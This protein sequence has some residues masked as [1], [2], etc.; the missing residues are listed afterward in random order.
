MAANVW[1]AVASGEAMVVDSGTGVDAASIVD[2]VRRAAA[3]AVVRRVHLTHWHC[4]HCGGAA[5]LRHAFGCPV[6]MHAEEARAVTDGDASLTLGAFL[7]LAQ[8]ACPVEPVKEG[9]TLELGGLRFEVLKLPGHTPASTCLFEPDAGALFAGD[10]AFPQGS[11]GRVDFPG[12]DA[13]AMLRSLERLA[14]L[15]ADALYSGHMEPVEGGARR[16]IR[17]S[18]ENAKG[19][20]S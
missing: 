9:D 20:L 14:A 12:G 18:L 7:G 3:D 1:V 10:V 15:E 6:T 2:E 4:D 8:P 17:E 16:A 5:A 11:F 19:M 13:D